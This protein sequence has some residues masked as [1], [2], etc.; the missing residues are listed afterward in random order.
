MRE[1]D[2]NLDQGQDPDL[3]QDLDQTTGIT[4]GKVPIQDLVQGLE[5]DF[6]AG[7]DE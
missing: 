1:D 7:E 4:K 6:I 3:D 5:A 2:I